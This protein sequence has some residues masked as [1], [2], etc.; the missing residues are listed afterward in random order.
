MMQPPQQPFIPPA[1]ASFNPYQQQQYQQPQMQ[2]Q[3]SNNYFPGADTEVN[4]LDQLS[5]QQQQVNQTY[6]D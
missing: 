3:N 2:Q 4:F 1:D 5:N 6:Q